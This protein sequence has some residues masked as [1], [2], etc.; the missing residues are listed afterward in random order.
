MRLVGAAAV[1]THGLDL[2]GDGPRPAAA[3]GAHGGGDRCGGRCAGV[4]LARCRGAFEGSGGGASAAAGRQCYASCSRT[5]LAACKTQKRRDG[6]PAAA[7][8][9]T[10]DE[11]MSVAT[12]AAGVLQPAP[13][14]LAE[15]SPSAG[16]SGTVVEEGVGDERDG[17]SPPPPPFL[18]RLEQRAVDELSHMLASLKRQQHA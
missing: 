16:M 6:G 7:A 12:V 9:A 18:S 4:C 8:A 10:G 3:D 11:E 17:P 14:D 5:C 1:K 2:G 13:L 15:G